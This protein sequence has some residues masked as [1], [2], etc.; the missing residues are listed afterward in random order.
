[1]AW[2]GQRGGAARKRQGRERES[3]TTSVRD[4]SES[5]TNSV[6]DYSAHTHRHA[7][8]CLNT[9]M[10]THTHTHT[11]TQRYPAPTTHSK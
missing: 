5:G 9:R 8:T 6:R 7:H 1:M 11:H 2:H 10:H 3:G 4:Y